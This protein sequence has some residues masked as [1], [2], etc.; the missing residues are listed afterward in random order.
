MHKKQVNLENLCLNTIL[1]IHSLRTK[2]FENESFHN[3]KFWDK[4]LTKLEE[5]LKDVY[6]NV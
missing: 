2:L 1:T 5:E 4:R 6:W 3:F